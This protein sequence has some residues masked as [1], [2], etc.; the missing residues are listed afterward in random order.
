MSQAKDK[1]LSG[2]L[3]P[4]RTELLVTRWLAQPQPFEP[5]WQRMRDYTD[6]RDAQSADQ[7][8]WL[9]H[10]P[11]FTLG[12]AGKSEHVLMP[13]DIPV[14]KTDRG[15]QVTYHGPGQ[16]VGYLLFDL[17][18]KSMGVRDLVTGIE[19]S[20][21]RLLATYGI[22]SMARPEAPGVYVGAKKIA[23]LGL[24]VRKGSSYHGLSL[25]VDLDPEPF[26]RINPCGY[27]GLEV[28]SLRML[29]IADDIGTV[30][31][32]LEQEVRQVFAFS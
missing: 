26:Q 13:G 16:L 4:A 29:G 1:L 11:V 32:K 9:V 3:S 12:Q 18:R 28:T 24:R 15:G 7:L 10:E 8:W 25:N 17:R 19:T 5:V 27:Q 14:V 22:E 23:A 21:I 30:A 6:Q 2:Q 31:D 20:I